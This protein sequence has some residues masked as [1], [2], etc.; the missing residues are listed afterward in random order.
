[1]KRHTRRAGTLGAALAGVLLLV[2]A[3][4]G[5]PSLT[6]P[7]AKDIKVDTPELVA[8][9]QKAA[10]EACPAATT[11]N[12]GLPKVVLPCLGGGQSV[13]LSTLTGP[14]LINVWS[15]ACEPCRKEMPALGE[16]HR[17]YGS[18]VPILGIDLE[19]TYPGVA[20]Q[21]AGEWKATYPQVFDFDGKIQETKLHV[22]A[23][24]TFIFLSAEGKVTVV[25]GGL[26]SVAKVVAMVNEH[27]GTTLS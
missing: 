14:L 6:A 2:L 23:L 19:D 25:K 5:S 13:D 10:I 26:D 20:L 9:K 11:S 15:S 8:L 4:C 24:P 27:L 16:F 1:M 17:T 7:K 18:Q 3:A 21:Q 12:G 22:P